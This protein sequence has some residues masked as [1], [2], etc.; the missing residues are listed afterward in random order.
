MRKVSA[1]KDMKAAPQKRKS[2]AMAAP[3]RRDSKGVV[4]QTEL[5]ENVSELQSEVRKR[6]ATALVA[7]FV[8]QTKNAEKQGT[9]KL[10]PG[11]PI[12][13]F[14]LRLGL[15]VE[16]AMYLNFWGHTGEPTTEYRQKLLS[17]LH[18]VKAN[19][20]LRDRLLNGSLPP[21][22][23]TKMS[24]DDMASKELQEKT[25]EMRKEVEKQHMLIQEEGPRI[26]R[27]HKGEEFIDDGSQ[28]I[29]G[30]E[31]IY[32]NVPAR[33]RESEMDL[34]ALKHTSP[35]PTSPQS[36]NVVELPNDVSY[37]G[38]LVSPTSGRSLSIDTRAPPRPPVGL[39]KKTSSAF[40][41]QNVWSSVDSPETDQQR[42]RPL[43]Q[44]QVS[45]NVQESP[46]GLGVE[47]DADIDHL[48]K[49][50]EPEDDEPYSPT[51]YP[52]DPGT[53]WR[54]KM[55]MA[56]VAEFSGTAKHVAGANLSGAYP[57]PQLMPHALSIEGRIS[58]DRASEYLCGLRWSKTTDLTVVAITPNDEPDTQAQFNK[59][60]NYFTERKRYGVVGKS[61]VS[62]VRDIYVVPLESGMG[63][64]PEFIE[65]LEYCTIEDPCPERMLLVTYVIKSKTDPTSS[66]QATPRH[67]D[68]ATAASPL[69][70]QHAQGQFRPPIPV[71]HPGSHMSPLQPYTGTASYGSPAQHQQSF[72]PPQQQHSYS[73]PPYTGNPVG[74]DA[75]RQVLGDMANSPAVGELLSQAP[76]T[77][78]VEFG[79][80][81]EFFESVPA[82]RND[83][84]MLMGLL[85][86]KSQQ[87]GGAV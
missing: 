24:S 67:L 61:P 85:K 13:A 17:I 47:V 80:I 42:I 77:G 8:E 55:V 29:A 73:P 27:T 79:I 60:F 21:N 82:C 64:K 48:L 38:T 57:W 36:P 45:E 35:A 10:P 41:I 46:S 39:D 26:R 58:I 44:R 16:Y 49:D 81:K 76:N 9:F 37:S 53:I 52:A 59:L 31:P 54:G 32:A 51:D 87:N 19:P 28:H 66:A 65:L 1:S 50:E 40:N 83:F 68:T 56:S 86:M 6:S 43:P 4:L 72:M 15:A 12:E 25:A 20:A 33:R 34:D 63:K 22:D 71:G 78:V 7:L 5:V 23:F 84:G 75:A 69:S 30:T 62:A 14:G 2:S 70:T 18:N 3:E 74:I 11:Q